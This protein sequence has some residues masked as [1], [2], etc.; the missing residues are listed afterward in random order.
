MVKGLVV[1]WVLL[2]GL[3][4]AAPSWAEGYTV[5]LDGVRLS[6]FVKVVYGDVLKL[7]YTF[8]PDFEDSADLVSIHLRN[9][10]SDTLQNVVRGML[11]Q[12]GYLLLDSGGVFVVHKMV[13]KADETVLIYHPKYRSAA[14]LSNLLAA[15]SPAVSLT[16][17]GI[18]NNAASAQNQ[19]QNQNQAAQGSAASFIDSAFSDQLVLDVDPKYYDQIQKLVTALDSPVQVVR[20]SAAVY[21]VNTGKDDG[22]ALS[23]VG[24]LV[25]GGS[26]LSPSLGMSISGADTVSLGFKGLTLAMSK[27]D[28]DSRFNSLSKPMVLVRSGASAVFS[29]GQKVPVLG[30]TTLTG[31]GLSQTSVNYMDSGIAFTVRPDVHESSIDLD[32]QQTISSFIATTTGVNGS[33]TLQQ[34]SLASSFTLKGS[35]LIAVGGLDQSTEQEQS[36]KSFFWFHSNQ[37]SLVKTSIVILIQVDRI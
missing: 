13:A 25:A 7:S 36:D 34:R 22:S 11:A 26:T 14:Y 37:K 30:S 9:S 10:S 29:V 32:I 8:E 5:N 28:S 6:E 21:E 3:L 23:L 15:V 33:P 18:A 17:R 24:S 27:L 19:N 16:H 2:F 31:G 4:L 20:V 12:R 35:E 1:K